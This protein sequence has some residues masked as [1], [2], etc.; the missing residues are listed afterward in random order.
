MKVLAHPV[1]T[2]DAPTF[3]GM[4]LIAEAYEAD[5]LTQLFDHDPWRTFLFVQA[6][7]FS[8][9][10]RSDALTALLPHLDEVD[11]R[12]AT[13]VFHDLIQQGRVELLDATSLKTDYAR[14]CFLRFPGDL[15]GLSRKQ[16]VASLPRFKVNG[17]KTIDELSAQLLQKSDHA[18]VV[19][20]LRFREGSLTAFSCGHVLTGKELELGVADLKKACIALKAPMTGSHLAEIYGKPP[21]PFMCPKCLVGQLNSYFRDR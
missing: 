1:P 12:T 3:S 6:R 16:L 21:I 9:L 15:S 18:T 10:S 5:F 11:A 14:A 13:E 19:P 2:T 17:R 4:K 8:D 20:S 7:R